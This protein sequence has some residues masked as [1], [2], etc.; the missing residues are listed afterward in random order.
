M[1]ILKKTNKDTN[2]SSI[3]VNSV[4]L[5]ETQAY[6]GKQAYNLNGV[7]IISLCNKRKK[8]WLP[9]FDIIFLGYKK[10]NQDWTNLQ[11]SMSSFFSHNS[12]NTIANPIVLVCWPLQQVQ[13]ERETIYWFPPK[14]KMRK[15]IFSTWTINLVFITSRGVVTAPVIAPVINEISWKRFS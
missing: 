15:Q 13:R 10:D 3:S 1:P 4:N 5:L 2:I 12:P 9:H 11:K 7:F 14:K 8:K 6:S